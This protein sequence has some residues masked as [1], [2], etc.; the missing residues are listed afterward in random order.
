MRLLALLILALA[1][2]LPPLRAAEA[3][4]FLKPNDV[5]ALIGGEDMVVANELGLLEMWLHSNLPNH[6]L[7]VR[8]LAWEGDT[9]FEQ[10]RDL[11]YPTLETQLAKAG[12]TVVICQFGQM[13]SLAG[14]EKVAEFTAAYE[15]L[16]ARLRGEGKRRLILMAP[17]YF[18]KARSTE[19]RPEETSPH[20]TFPVPA[21]NPSLE[22]YKQAVKALA[23]DHGFPFVGTLLSKEELLAR[24]AHVDSDFSPEWPSTLN[25]RD[26]VH[27]GTS[28][29]VS[30]LMYLHEALPEIDVAPDPD[31]EEYDD[32]G[33]IK[34]HPDREALRQLILAKN[35]LWF[36]Y[37]RPQNWAFLAGDRTNQ[38][39]SRDYRDPSKRWFPDEMEKFVPLIDAKEQEIW[40]A[41][42]KLNVK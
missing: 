41:A 18:E 23:K 20:R 22:A 5:I 14:K 38:P 12:A 3:G 28:G 35:R 19:E 26:G 9:V 34:N 37:T 31:G 10:H 39:S 4:P 40:N 24:G 8:S 42:A 29:H 25:T 6:H 32:T 27:A 13:E 15:K 33:A 16:I 2:A 30:R 1:L 17:T 7:K 21:P 36:E 11:N